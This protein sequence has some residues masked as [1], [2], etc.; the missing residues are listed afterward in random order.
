MKGLNA[1][2]LN[3]LGYLKENLEIHYIDYNFNGSTDR[4]GLLGV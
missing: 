3:I 2:Y 1:K 4:S